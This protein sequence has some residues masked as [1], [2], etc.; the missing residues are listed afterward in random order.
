[1]RAC[2]TNAN[3]VEKRQAIWPNSCLKVDEMR[4]GDANELGGI[5]RRA[6]GLEQ[7]A[8]YRAARTVIFTSAL[9]QSRQPYFGSC[10]FFPLHQGGS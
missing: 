6:R 8:A 1:M 2:C 9:K 4:G 7:Q 5:Q 3:N 10:F